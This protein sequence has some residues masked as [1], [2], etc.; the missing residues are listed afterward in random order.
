MPRYVVNKNVDEH[1]EHEVHREGCAYFPKE[2]VEL[3]YHDSCETAVALAKKVYS[4][5]DGCKYC[6]RA[7]H[8]S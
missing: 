1:G 5:S 2:C 4:N 3:G 7:S 6:A 8:V